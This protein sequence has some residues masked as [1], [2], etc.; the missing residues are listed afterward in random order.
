MAVTVLIPPPVRVG[1]LAVVPVPVCIGAA[2]V[3]DGDESSKH[4]E[5]EDSP[6]VIRADEPPFPYGP[7]LNAARMNWVPE[8]IFVFQTRSSASNKTRLSTRLAH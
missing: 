6:T 5:F 8:A 2:G 3:E 1:P 4:P 7:L